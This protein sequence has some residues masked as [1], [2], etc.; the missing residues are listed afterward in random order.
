MAERCDP[1]TRERQIIALGNLTKAHRRNEAEI[2]AITS[3]EYQGRGLGTEL[4]R[5]LI[6]MMREARG[7]GAELV[8][9]PELA[10]TTRGAGS[11]PYLQDLGSPLWRYGSDQI[12]RAHV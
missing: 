11:L 10:L 2:A 8:V 5:R 6:A 9:F 3:D 1:H 4:V 7:R 12:G